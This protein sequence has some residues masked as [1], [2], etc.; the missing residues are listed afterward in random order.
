MKQISF[1]CRVEVECVDRDR[2]DMTSSYGECSE[3]AFQIT[4]RDHQISTGFA[5]HNVVPKSAD[6]DS[7]SSSWI[8]AWI[9]FAESSKK[10]S[11]CRI[12]LII[13]FLHNF[14]SDGPI[15]PALRIK[16]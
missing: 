16:D 6:G 3:M 12:F 2:G 11:P 14:I 7:L 1:S 15:V 4:E 9:P 10:A 5:F 8:N 13:E